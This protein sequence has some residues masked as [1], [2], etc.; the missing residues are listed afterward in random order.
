MQASAAPIKIVLTGD[1]TMCNYAPEKPSRGWGQFLAEHFPA[2]S[3]EV[4]NL[5]ASGRSTKTFRKEGRWKKALAEQPDYI[6]IQFGHNDSHPPQNKE[7]TDFAT[8]YQENLKRFIDES[9]A[10]GAVPVLVTPMV[11]RIFSDDGK[12]LET[13]ESPSRPLVAYADAVKKVATE[14]QVALV[15]LYTSSKALAEKLGPEASQKFANRKGD[16]T[17]FNE[18][19][20]RAM[21]T[22]VVE[23][24]PKAV[25]DLKK[26]GLQ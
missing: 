22:L 19:G 26:S 23:Q 4:I 10:I 20:A 24:L 6:F 7:S 18:K 11:R 8:D 12:I 14:K 2:G 13:A 16:P 1:S 9:R 3:V 21:T 5:A 15:D 25:P 17:H